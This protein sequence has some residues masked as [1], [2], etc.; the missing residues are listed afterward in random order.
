[1]PPTDDKEVTSILAQLKAGAV[2]GEMAQAA[3]QKLRH[4][5]TR[6]CRYTRDEAWEIIAGVEFD[7]V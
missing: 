5:G 6:L 7:H 1:M 4:P 2:A 3:I